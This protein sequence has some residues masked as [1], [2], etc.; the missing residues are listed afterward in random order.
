M[1][2]RTRGAGRMALVTVALLVA[3]T[4]RREAERRAPTPLDR[5]TVC[6]I[7]GEVRFAG[8]PPASR[9]VDMS[10]AKDCAAQHPAGPVDAGDVRVQNGKVQDAIVAITGGLGDRV[11]AVPETPIV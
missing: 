7:A 1:T 3:A 8:T 5:S 2:N 11:F 6:V 4:C 9:T 10:S